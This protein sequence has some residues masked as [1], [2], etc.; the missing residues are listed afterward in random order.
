MNC[1]CTAP[2]ESVESAQEYLLLLLETIAET[3]QAIQDDLSAE[4][5]SRSSRRTDA[6]HLVLYNV[7]KLE[8][9]TRI[10]RRILND[11]RTLRRVLQQER[12]AY[13]RDRTEGAGEPK[14]DLQ[15]HISETSLPEPDMAGEKGINKRQN[16]PLASALHP[17][18]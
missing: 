3:R 6:L 14:R 9:H 17:A 2:F 18:A 8:H 12:I 4:T 7:E 15:R 11:L 5:E 1:E 16:S 13:P 10:S